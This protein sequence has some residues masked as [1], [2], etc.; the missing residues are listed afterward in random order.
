VDDVAQRHGFP[1]AIVA[2]ARLE[3]PRLDAVLAEHGRSTRFRGVR[4]MLNWEPG[5]EVAERPGI[6]DDPAWAEGLGLLAERGLSFD[7]QVFPSQLLRAAEIVGAHP[8]V[9]FVLDH[10]GYVQERTD[11]R[12]RAWGAG[13]RE[14]A[15]APNVVVKATSYGSVEPAFTRAGLDRYVHELVEAFGVERVLWGSNYPVERR[16]VGYRDQL[17]AYAAVTAGWSAGDREAFYAE[18]ALRVYRIAAE[19]LLGYGAPMT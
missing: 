18:N 5:E 7:L 11:E 4:Q 16:H 13:L 8:G 14:L 10:G 15:A 9:Q 1:Q 17:E 6:L 12:T 19:S 2:F 3:D